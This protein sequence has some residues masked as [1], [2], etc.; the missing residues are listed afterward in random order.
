MRRLHVLFASL[1]LALL[2][3]AP[4][5]VRADERDDL[6]VTMEVLDEVGD[7]DRAIAEMDGPDL[8]EVEDE[9][10]EDEDGR[11]REDDEHGSARDQ[12][13]ASE[14]EYEDDYEDEDED[15]LEEEFEDDFED[16]FEHGEED[17]TEDD[18]EYEDDFED[19]EDVD[20]DE[21]D[22]EDDEEEDDDELVAD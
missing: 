18:M 14:D 4:A 11:T 7:L 3:L 21:F 2:A 5:A 15:E 20:E 10:W 1:A 12:D 17:E 13:S 16:E 22:D 19:G 8:G 6:D 9:D